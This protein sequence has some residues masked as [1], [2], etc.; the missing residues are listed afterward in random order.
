[1]IKAVC[2]VRLN[3]HLNSYKNSRLTSQFKSVFVIVIIYS[4]PQ[5]TIL[6]TDYNDQTPLFTKPLYIGKAAENDKIG[7]EVITVLARDKDVGFRGRVSYRI[8][9]G[10]DGGWFFLVFT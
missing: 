1:M 10:N 9:G 3:L 2:D 7:S 6:V 4:P 8:I 5:I